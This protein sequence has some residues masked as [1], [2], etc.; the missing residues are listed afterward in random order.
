MPVVNGAIPV[1]LLCV[2]LSFNIGQN[3]CQVI[4]TL[5]FKPGPKEVRQVLYAIPMGAL[6]DNFRSGRTLKCHLNLIDRRNHC[7]F[8]GM[9]H[10]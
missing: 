6:G 3:A 5:F 10:K 9:P 1:F 4:Y 2:N 7:S 8:A